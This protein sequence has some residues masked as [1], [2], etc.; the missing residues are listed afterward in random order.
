[1]V[2]P[3]VDAVLQAQ[4]GIAKNLKI[5]LKLVGH[6][7][8][9][10]EG[11]VGRADDEHALDQ[12]AQ[13]EFLEQQAGHDGL[14]GPCVVGQKE[15]HAGGFEQVVVNGI[16]LVGQRVHTAQRQAEERVVFLGERNAEGFDAQLH[17]ARVAGGAG[18]RGF[19][20]DRLAIVRR[21]R[22]A[23]AEGL[24]ARA[25][26]VDD[27]EAI[28]NGRDADD[29]HRFAELGSSQYQG[30]GEVRGLQA[31]RSSTLRA[32][33]GTQDAMR[34]RVFFT[35]VPPAN[36]AMQLATHGAY[37]G[38]Q[39]ASKKQRRAPLNRPLAGNAARIGR[40]GATNTKRGDNSGEF[41]APVD[42]LDATTEGKVADGKWRIEDGRDGLVGTRESRTEPG[43]MRNSA[44]S[45][46]L[47]P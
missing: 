12:T 24:G 30:V 15:T 2:V 14:A 4:V 40:V 9:P 33:H 32:T 16:K 7:T 22:D 43:R 1:M 20:P 17:E 23:A 42:T 21:Q 8:L 6:F 37:C 46:Y 39:R 25:D 28:P 27:L 5:L 38:R 26:E 31:H 36:A 44:A 47:P 13:L 3:F 45:P 41:E 10:L 18:F 34:L 11:E 29:A 19:G 35:R